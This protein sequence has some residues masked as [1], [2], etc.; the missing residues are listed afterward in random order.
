MFG[1]CNNFRFN[2]NLYIVGPD[3][4]VKDYEKYLLSFVRSPKQIFLHSDPTSLNT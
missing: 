3:I 1:Y 2:Y 4:Y